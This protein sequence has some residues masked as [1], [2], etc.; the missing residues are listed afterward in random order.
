MQLFGGKFNT[1]D[2]QTRSNFDDFLHALLTVFQI[3][4][5]EDWNS[6]MYSGIQAYEGPAK[7]GVTILRSL[8]ISKRVSA[9]LFCNNDQPLGMVVSVYF[10]I[11]FVFG[12]YILLNVFL[13]IA[14]DNLADAES[15]T[16][17][18]LGSTV[19]RCAQ[20]D[21]ITIEANLYAIIYNS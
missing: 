4:T 15:L 9:R 13:A 20:I 8:L 21:F 14:V 12:N 6:V 3:L 17:S 2:V 16:K 18:Q 11:L 7:A 5:G 1:I 19:I 10:I